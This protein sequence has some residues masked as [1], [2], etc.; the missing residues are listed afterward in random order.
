MGD[1]RKLLGAGD[2]LLLGGTD[3]RVESVEGCGGSSVVY[4][5]SYEDRLNHE[6]RHYVLI[7]ELFPYHP[8]GDIY[9]GASGEICCRGDGAGIMERH[10]Q[11][12]YRGNQAN[13]RL[14]EKSP[15]RVSGNI[16]SYSAYGTFYSV[17]SIHGGRSL[18][19]ILEDR[20]K[21]WSLKETAEIILKILEAV[22]CF[23]DSGIL[24]LDISPDNILML[25]EQAFLIDYNSV[26]IIGGQDGGEYYFSEKPGYS[27]PEVRLREWKNIGQATDIYSVCAV[28]FRML[29]GRSLAYEDIVENRLRK[30]LGQDLEIFRGESESAVGKTVQIATKG[31]HLL[32]RKRYESVDGLREDI[33]QLIKLMDESK[34]ALLAWQN[35]RKTRAALALIMLLLAGCACVWRAQQPYQLNAQE[36]YQLKEAMYQVTRNLAALGMQLDIQQQILECALQKEVLEGD[37]DALNRFYEMLDYKR[38]EA[39]HYSFE[40]SADK[41]VLESLDI[42]RADVP[43][44]ILEELLDKTYDMDVIMEEGLAHLEDEFKMTSLSYTDRQEVAAFYR[45]YLDAYAE[46]AYREMCLVMARLDD[47][48][49]EEILDIM[50]QVSVLK[51]Y[52]SICPYEGKSVRQLEAELSTAKARMKQ[53]MND[54][55]S[56]NYVISAESWNGD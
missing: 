35:R 44:D 32:A 19:K 31:L 4:R 26:W 54:M 55:R 45:D 42:P 28:W 48:T 41:S 37:K 39:G 5:A 38:R 53:C 33:R 56:R 15:E 27:A 18:G 29:T 46:A 36:R 23:H 25:P 17:L 20:Q 49:A 3:Y 51:D 50:T 13:L 8:K 12:F 9:R 21:P 52:I 6:C 14:L 2:I 7:K 40:R 34:A 24:H 22:E 47:E 43:V 1:K 30:S 16:N 11:S 10:M